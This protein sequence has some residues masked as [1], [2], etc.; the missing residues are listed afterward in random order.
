MRPETTR[1]AGR[2]GVRALTNAGISES[3]IAS[4]A[5][6]ADVDF[7]AENLG[8][9]DALMLPTLGVAV[10]NAPP[11]NREGF[12]AMATASD[13]VTVVEA[14]RIVY[15]LDDLQIALEEIDTPIVPR[16]ATPHESA[17]SNAGSD[18]SYWIGYR[19]AVNQL[20]E[21]MLGA[22]ASASGTGIGAQFIDETAS[23]WGL[24]ATRVAQSNFTGRGIRVAVLDTGI[25]RGHPDFAD[26]VVRRRSFIQGQSSQDGHGHGTHCIGTAC[27]SRQP[28]QPP[29]YGVAY[30]A[31]IYA[32]KVLSNQG[33]GADGGILAGIEWA[34]NNKCQ[35]IS[36]SLGSPTSL[37]QAFSPIYEDVAQTALNNGTLII[38]AAGNESS[39]P[40]IIRPVSHPA[41]C[42]S[43][44]SV[45]AVD[46]AL[47]IASFSCGGLNTN[48]G[49]VDIAG[50]G[51]NVLS[52]FPR[53]SN[54][55]RL[56]GTSMA[57][58][59]VAGIAALHAQASGARG[60]RLWQILVQTARS[61]PLS[62]RDVG[63]GIV[64][65]P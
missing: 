12:R 19:D 45:A 50:P 57:T 53:P 32:G 46:S 8:G 30:E 47:R 34:I 5:D 51:V 10:V 64:Q 1:G 26:R 27:G 9:A 31:E 44:M 41:D 42:P 35:I 65:A 36:M 23:T 61:L 11:D 33:S 59:H 43:I 58:P 15:A 28:S 56:N 54:Y 60:M 3:N 29:R 18:L 48:G 37:G 55:R 62:S 49:K 13:A 4:M 7:D 24:Q 20:V 2:A 21:K 25:D 22:G 17:G 14:E 63:A 16:T 40:G 38:A 52:T 39:R 6:F